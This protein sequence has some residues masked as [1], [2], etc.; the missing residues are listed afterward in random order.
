MN[1]LNSRQIE[2][3]IT[4]L[5]WLHIVGAALFL[6]IGFFV[7]TLLT[8]IG[9]ASGEPEAVRVLSV[10]GMAVGMFLAA[11]SIPGIAAGYGLLAHKSWGQVLAIVVGVLNLIN[12]PIGTIIGAYT[13]LVLLQDSANEYFRPETP[14]RTEAHALK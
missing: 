2:Q 9:A 4:I 6:L 13:L 5:G 3:H 7:F 1:Q 10:V 12:F 8:G 14:I 11:L